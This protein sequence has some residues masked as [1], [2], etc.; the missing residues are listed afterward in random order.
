MYKVYLFRRRCPQTAVHRCIEEFRLESHTLLAPGCSYCWRMLVQ[1]VEE[2]HS[3]L[4]G[5]L[6]FLGRVL[7]LEQLELEPDPGKLDVTTL[8]L[9]EVRSRFIF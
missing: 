7:P 5:E 1:E 9:K 4:E 3:V 2:A 8:I 6:A